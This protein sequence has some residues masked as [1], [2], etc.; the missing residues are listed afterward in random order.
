MDPSHKDLGP[1][2]RIPS[3]VESY[4][5]SVLEACTQHGG[6]LASLVLFGSAVKGG[7]TRQVSD[8][9]LIVVLPDGASQQERTRVRDEVRRLE[10]EYGFRQPARRGNPLRAFA[11]RVCGHDLS[12]FICTRGDLLSGEVA[13]VF[14]LNP[15]EA[16]V[17][18][19]IVFANVL[20]SSATA[21]GENLLPSVRPP[22]VR[23]LDVFKAYVAFTNQVL[24]VL[25][26]YGLLP[27]ATR[28]AMSTL[29]HSLH[30]CYFCFH[31]KTATLDEEVSFFRQQFRDSRTLQRLLE[32]RLQYR[33]SF[34]FVLRCLPAL[35]R[36]QMHTAWNN[37][38]PFE[39][40]A[41][42]SRES[43]LPP[44]DSNPD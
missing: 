33:P 29:K 22:H 24:F 4:L 2:V 27:D 16:L 1:S 32:L 5:R 30:S 21:W 20:A 23:R 12:S 7:F 34:V 14:G 38:F 6:D 13:R 17:V 37:A 11:D 36:L 8:V 3:L 42:A 40:P 44:R 19:R 10:I 25:I 15:L 43:W 39:I 9:D 41:P 35:L 26:V 28:Y 18:D 31:G